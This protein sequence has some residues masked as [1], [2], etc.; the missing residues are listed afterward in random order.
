MRRPLAALALLLAACPRGFAEDPPRDR[1][2][3]LLESA[4]DGPGLL[5]RRPDDPKETAEEGFSDGAGGDFSD[6]I[7]A[8]D[9]PAKEGGDEKQDKKAA[10]KPKDGKADRKACEK[11]YLAFSG[12]YGDKVDAVVAPAGETLPTPAE[13][14]FIFSKVQKRMNAVGPGDASKQA[15]LAKLF[16]GKA[17]LGE[18]AERYGEIERAAELERRRGL[19]HEAARARELAKADAA[20]SRE[21]GASG[22]PGFQGAAPPPAVSQQNG[23]PGRTAGAGVGRAVTTLRITE[24]PDTSQMPPVENPIPQ[25][26]PDWAWEA[27]QHSRAKLGDTVGS[28]G[29]PWNGKL[30]GGVALPWS[31]DGFKFVRYGRWGTS[32][33]I[34]GIQAIAKDIN[35]PG[36]RPLEVGDISYERGGPIRSHKSHQNGRDVDLFFAADGKGR[37]D[38]DRNLRLVVAAVRRMN[39]VNIFVDTR[40][41]NLLAQH[42]RLVVSK[43]PEQAADIKKALDAMSYEPGHRDHFHIRIGTTE[44]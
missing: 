39:V 21:F 28:L 4:C 11:Q 27:Y 20:S 2:R 41:K 44:A 3:A 12:R 38:V 14:D 29:L 23:G 10:P 18:V 25:Y 36:S 37:F 30:V 7:E 34:L 26:L 33:M 6:V 43:Q 32:A 13:S 5:I 8:A 16:D 9:P 1:G 35:D 17:S 40:Y 19:A 42:A 31:G 22:S 24:P 15:A